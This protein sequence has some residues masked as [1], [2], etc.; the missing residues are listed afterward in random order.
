MIQAGWAKLQE[1][2]A[3]RGLRADTLVVQQSS[4]AG[5]AGLGFGSAFQNGNGA[6][7]RGDADEARY[8]AGRGLDG[9]P[10]TTARTNARLTGASG[11]VDYR[12]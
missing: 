2:L 10:G 7:T 3:E 12:V 11:L 8:V 6:W 9:E 4:G 1:G 5:S